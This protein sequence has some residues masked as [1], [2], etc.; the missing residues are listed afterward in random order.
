MN[1]APS[2]V[3]HFRATTLVY[4]AVT[5]FTVVANYIYALFAHGVSSNAMTYMF[6]YPLVGGVLPALLFWVLA[7][8]GARLPRSREAFNLY[9]AGIATLTV[10]S[11]LQGVFE[12]AGTASEYTTTLR[13]LG[14][15]LVATGLLVGIVQHLM[16]TRQ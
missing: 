10:T 12:I 5:V 13:I 16:P 6:L 2:D 1:K 14:A 9:N 3:Q 15:G 7:I 8:G 11:F 4:A